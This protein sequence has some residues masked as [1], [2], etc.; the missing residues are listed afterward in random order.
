MIFTVDVNGTVQLT[1]FLITKL[2]IAIVMSGGALIAILVTRPT[3]RQNRIWIFRI[4]YDL[5]YF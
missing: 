1:F 5:F 2:N 4:T 3:R